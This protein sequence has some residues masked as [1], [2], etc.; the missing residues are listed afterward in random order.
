MCGIAGIV[1]PSGKLTTEQVRRLR[2]ALQ[3]RGPDAAGVWPEHP[4][5]RT[6]CA[7]GH[8]RLSIIDLS[9][10]GR[11]P[12]SNA[13]GT[14][15]ITFNGE[16]YNYLSLRA[17][18][19]QRGY[20]FRTRTDTETILAAWERWGTDCVKHLRGMFAFALWD[21]P[22]RQLFL[23]RDRV[24]KKPLFYT[25]LGDRFLFAS[26]LQAL[27]ADLDVPRAINL[28][29]IERYLTLGYIPAPDTGFAAIHKLPPA[30]SLLLKVT[31]EGFTQQLER[32]WQLNYFPKLKL[33]AAEAHAA[34]RDKLTK[35]TRLRL[36]SD[37]PLGAFLSGGIDSSIVVGLMAQLSRERVK[38]FSIGF[39][40]ASFNETPHARRIAEKWNTDHHEFIIEPKA[41]E[42]LPKLVRHYGEPYAD[43]SAVPTFYLSQLTR[44]HVT[45]ALNGDGGDESFAGYERYF[46]NRMAAWMQSVPGGPWLGKN[47]SRLLP[48][49]ANPK[50]RLRTLQ[51]FLSVSALPT[52]Q[53]YAHWVGN[54]HDA[55]Q[56]ELMRPE[57]A[58]QLQTIRQPDYLASLFAPL[59][60]YDP[61][62]ACM[63]VD[64]QSYLPFDLLVKVDIASMANSL[65]ARSPLLDHE[66][67][68]FA[69]RLPISLKAPGLSQKQLLKQVFA[70]LLPPANVNRRKM[71]FGVP[72][73]VWFRHDLRDYTR[74]A[75]LSQSTRLYEF[76]HAAVIERYL[77]E[78]QRGQADH[79]FRLWNLL[80]FE[81]WLQEFRVQV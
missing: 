49:S 31:P 52:A 16:I 50:H 13:A 58:A 66:V 21:E 38:T 27:L 73:A 54:F 28:A 22:R 19:E 65:E 11:Q 23:A 68:E 57:F 53:R 39:A 42:I 51:R 75:L 8:R 25:Q 77:N 72:L 30:H 34:L 48:D 24:G 40:E 69:A 6:I 63:S 80:M 60:D 71:G 10:A 67:M 37:V 64:V 1:S 44:Q 46:G 62:D 33:S 20:R 43:S 41:L 2:D 70:D 59:A 17:E 55:E 7:L 26:E 79:S 15:W 81:L 76:F 78:H 35:A 32:Y 9:E 12:M 18:L 14:V 29:A 61:V 45:V 3:H 74:E 4:D 5:A 56:H 36:M 47:L